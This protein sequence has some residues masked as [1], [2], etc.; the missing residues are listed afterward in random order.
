MGGG[1]GWKGVCVEGVCV[2]EGVCV[3]ISCGKRC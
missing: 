3:V 1:R 2:S